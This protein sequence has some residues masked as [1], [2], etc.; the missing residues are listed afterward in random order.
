MF[1]ANTI[2]YALTWVRIYKQAR[3]IKRTLGKTESSASSRAARSMS[4][5]VFVFFIQWW[6]MFV[7][8]LWSLE[9]SEIP[10]VMFHCQVIF[11]NLGG[12]LNFVVYVIIRR[13][14]LRFST[15]NT[16]A[17]CQESVENVPEKAPSSSGYLSGHL[18]MSEIVTNSS[19]DRADIN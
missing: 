19:S 13:R 11:A 15:R 17:V 12:V 9:G 7:F 8:G 4:L 1:S 3:E 16:E 14:Q 5:F 2:L 10:Q 6:P 18:V